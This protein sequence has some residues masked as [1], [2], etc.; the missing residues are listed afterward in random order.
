LLLN[1]TNGYFHMMQHQHG[2]GTDSDQHR[3]I[4]GPTRRPASEFI[5]VRPFDSGHMIAV[6]GEQLATASGPAATSGYLPTVPA[7]SEERSLD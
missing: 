5:S 4:A 3:G 1:I 6:T 2:A 7:D